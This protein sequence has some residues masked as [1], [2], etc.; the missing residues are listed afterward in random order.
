MRHEIDLYTSAFD[1][2]MRPEPVSIGDEAIINLSADGRE[3]DGF[4]RLVRAVGGELEFV[5]F[6]ERG[7]YELEEWSV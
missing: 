2:A 4:L 3:L 7:G 6:E 1:T 5:R